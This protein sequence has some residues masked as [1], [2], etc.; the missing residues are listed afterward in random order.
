MGFD[1]LDER[2]PNPSTDQL[3]PH[4]W[5]SVDQ[6][7][8]LS[9][10]RF[11]EGGA[12]AE[13]VVQKTPIAPSLLLALACP[14]YD[15]F[16]EAGNTTQRPGTQATQTLTWN[17]EGKLATTGEPA[18]GTKPALN[19]NYLY[20][21]DGELLIRRAT[22]DGDTVLYLG[23]TEVRLTTAGT[24]KTLAGTR[25]YSA[26][27]QTIAVRT[28]TAGVAGTKLT[29]LA[30][31]HHGT[32]SLAI[33]AE[34][35][36]VTRRYS[37]P[38]GSPRGTDTTSAWPDDKTFLGKPQD[39]ATG[40]I[41]IGA[42]EYDSAVGQFI[43]VDPVLAPELHQSLNGYSYANNTP[44]TTADPTGLR[45][46]TI[47][48]CGGTGP[49]TTTPPGSDNCYTGNMS[50]SCD[51]IGGN[52][53][54]TGGGGGGGGGGGDGSSGTAGGGDN[55]GG[56]PNCGIFSKC[57][58]SNAWNKG[59][60]W[61][62][63]NK[64]FL[65]QVVTEVAVGTACIGAATAAG[66]ATAGAGFVAAAG[67][68]A[69]A[70]AA[71]SAV[72]N[73]M[74]PEADHSVTGQLGD[75]ANGAI[76]GATGGLLGA[77]AGHVAQTI[78]AKACHSFLPGTG[79][80]LA[81]GSRKAIEDVE[82]GD[83][84]V[85]T[86]AATGKTTEKKVASTITTEGDKDFTDITVR[87][88]E[89]FS[90]ITATDTHPFWV[91]ELDEWVNAGDLQVGQW[92]RT[93]A[94]THVQISALSSYTRPQRTHDLSIEDI[95]AYYVLAESTPL[96]V[97]NCG[98]ALLARAR[99]LFNTRTDKETTVA[100]ARVRSVTDPENTQTWVATERVGIPN[101]W[102]NANAPR[103]QQGELYKSGRGHAE[104]TI[105][106]ALGSQWE[107]TTMASSTRMCPTCYAQA[108]GLGLRK[109]KIG[110]GYGP[111]KNTPWRV[112]E[113]PS[114]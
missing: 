65:A 76:W 86:S 83:L 1:P 18:A 10:L 82:V 11:G 15:E 98:N 50:P 20:D 95:H 35:Q 39:K 96:L 104:A 56:K 41:H 109:S 54:G 48:P 34:T 93:S 32:S 42:R 8:S 53:M 58:L 17:S 79:V 75:M 103:P 30:A 114:N 91:P 100:V 107:I 69:L 45:P 67:C 59:V 22:G 46:D 47:T 80:L 97:H 55:G 94:G 26:V 90:S 84:V 85:T 7:E 108:K 14:I 101:E 99:T 87:V 44:V 81:D 33:D 77:G 63:D 64:V 36:A 31:D 21:A 19:T 27:G 60:D 5:E 6:T 111:S 62:D 57:G 71:G 110:M 4:G 13:A 9:Y 38:F 24:K 66:L 72:S 25:Y 73:A 112:V 16:D 2:V 12:F 40:L 88:D 89:D 68:G 70:G 52:N 102:R 92:L 28:A 37:T 61:V 29:F 49:C 113:R 51:G 23:S 74:S 3:V 43:S 78:I 105:M 106:N